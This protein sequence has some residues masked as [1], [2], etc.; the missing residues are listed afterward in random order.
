MPITE[1][2]DVAAPPIGNDEIV[3][4]TDVVPHDAVTSTTAIVTGVAVF[5]ITSIPFT[6]LGPFAF[7]LRVIASIAATVLTENKLGDFMK[8][9][10]IAHPVRKVFKSKEGMAKKLRN[11]RENIIEEMKEKITNAIKAH[12]EQERVPEKLEEALKENATR[13]ATLVEG[14]NHSL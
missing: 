8:G 5:A 9:A 11:E 12:L 1:V 7:A 3:I 10:N 4:P 14:R 6:V 2:P 13:I